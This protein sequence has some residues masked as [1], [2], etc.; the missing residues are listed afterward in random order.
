MVL[1]SRWTVY[2]VRLL[3]EMIH[4]IPMPF[5]V[6]PNYIQNIYKNS[7]FASALSWVLM[8][9]NDVNAANA[10]FLWVHFFVSLSCEHSIVLAVIFRLLI[11]LDLC[12]C[13]H[14]SGA[15]LPRAWS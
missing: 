11:S 14:R 5:R 3:F 2:C 1:V 4:H 10:E 15:C 6:F 13:D 12:D 8:D 9:W 7:L